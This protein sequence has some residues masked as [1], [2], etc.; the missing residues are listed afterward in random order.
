MQNRTDQESVVQG[1]TDS[2]VE[3][4]LTDAY[5]VPA[6]PRTLLKR[7]DQAVE[8]EWGVSPELAK[9]EPTPMRRVANRGS[10]L[11]RAWPIAASIALLVAALVVFQ[12]D[13]HAYSWAKML[14]ALSRMPTVEV[15][16]GDGMTMRWMSVKKAIVGERS[17][18][19]SWVL[20]FSRGIK[21]QREAGESQAVRHT[22]TGAKSKSLEE[23]MLIAFLLDNVTQEGAV[24]RQTD[25][26][27]VAEQWSRRGDEIVLDVKLGSPQQTTKLSIAIDPETHLPKNAVVAGD[28]SLPFAFTDSNVRFL[29][30]D[31]PS[32]LLVIDAAPAETAVAV[33]DTEP[34]PTVPDEAVAVAEDKPPVEATPEEVELVGAATL[35]WPAVKVTKLSKDEAVARIDKILEALWKE[36]DI[37]PAEAA[38]D[39]ELLRRVYLDLAG[40]TPSVS[41]V[42]DYL[43]DESSDRYEKLVDQLLG[44]RDH[45]THLA[46]VWRTYLIPEGIDLARF[47]G[48]Q[49]FEKWIGEQFK[50]EVPYDEIVRRLLLAE[51]R[52]VQ[53]GP[54]LF[55]AAVKMDPDQ[56]A[57]RSARV[58]L[59]MRL[60]CAQCHDDRFEP[61]LQED[62]WGYAAFFAQISRP[63]GVLR[64]VSTVMR[65]RD[66]KRGEVKI[67][68]TEDVVLPRFLDG[69]PINNDA[70][71]VARRTQLAEWLTAADNPYF[72]RA[73]VNRIW[74]QL[75]GKGIVEPVDGFGIQHKPVSQD[76]LDEVAGHFIASNY[77]LR[78]LFRTIVLSRAYRLSSGAE[79]ADPKRHELFAQMNVKLLTAE[80]MYDC[81]TVAS[82][83]VSAEAGTGFNL[84]R[85]GNTTRD[86]FLQQFRAPPGR[87]TEYQAGIPQ[88]LTLMNGGLISN[89]TGLASS[90]LLKTLEVPL[91]NNK[92]RVEILYMATLSRT[93]TASEQQLLG[94]YIT[95]DAS[96]AELY[97]PLADVLWALLNSAEFTM[98]H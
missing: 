66:T 45:A 75:F 10:R 68:E 20:D 41:E 91:I 48:P 13:A 21:L 98:N 32:D 63:Q 97:E 93:A 28:P 43:G 72:A 34:K 52:L 47:G 4:M 23:S 77:D 40:R 56:L 18:E 36:N 64:D 74:G 31:F 76:L 92:D 67:P 58:F 57:T 90:G 5:E 38:S 82:M 85:V 35:Q 71:S 86:Q 44:S 88:A 39:E 87:A 14:D 54:L 80:Q 89:A 29:E 59:G 65:V 51:G 33:E 12:K 19:R 81:I 37:D 78:E 30:E 62:F 24:V 60:D 69:S 15:A 95:E 1:A 79:T 42:R 8:Q 11:L 17:A 49:S 25:V 16:K 26:S 22:F 94:E 9:R 55:Y 84:A 83:L 73:T 96:G 53:S 50:D 3:L 27:L 70:A 46:T 61:W 6:L 7:L 2:E